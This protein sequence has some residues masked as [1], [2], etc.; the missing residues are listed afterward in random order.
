MSIDSLLAIFV[1]VGF[2]I[3]TGAFRGTPA[4]TAVLASGTTGFS[5]RF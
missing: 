2:V 4:V 5:D 1:S 3:V